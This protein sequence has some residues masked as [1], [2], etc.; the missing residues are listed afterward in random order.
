[1]FD[2][3]GDRLLTAL[4]A[5]GEVD[6][7]VVDSARLT[8][9]INAELEEGRDRLLEL[10]SHQP[11]RAAELVETLR[12]A[13]GVTKV[14]DYMVAYWDAFGVEH[15]RGPGNST[16][17]RPGA[18]MLNEHMPGLSAEALTV[19]FGRG[20]ALAHE[21]RQ[22]LTWEHPMVRGSM[23]MLTSG[24]LG[25]AAVTVCSHP[26]HR[27]GTVFL[28]VLFVTECA[29]PRG[30]EIQ[31]YLPP[32]C[33]RFLLDT[34]GE[35]QSALLPHEQLTGLCL[36]QNRKLADTVIKSQGQRI[37]LLLA[38][39]EELAQARGSGLAERAL[40]QMNGELGAEQQR[41]VAL[42]R[43][44]PNV[45]DDEIEQLGV[46]RELIAVHLRDTRVR[47]DAVR[48]VVMR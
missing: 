10:H 46:R 8:A 27:T 24:E 44:N 12:T 20:D 23:E 1:M 32:T 3:L 37:K 16:V 2:R 11:E 25:A 35:D 7:L 17:L 6:Q 30:L 47:L 33:L 28:E 41:L 5:P 36:S 40:L 42:A 4:A 14:N 38:H 26:D 18:H 39:A 22:F 19:T 29:A 15:E 48:V 43:V 45:R 31:R 34:Q 13:V 21:D 9:R